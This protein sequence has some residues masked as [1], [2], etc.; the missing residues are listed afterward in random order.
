MDSIDE[1]MHAFVAW[2]GEIPREAKRIEDYRAREHAVNWIR[3]NIGVGIVHSYVIG[4]ELAERWWTLFAERIDTIAPDGAEC[5]HIEA[6]NHNGK[7]WSSRFFY[8]P[9]LTRWRHIRF[10]DDGD[11]YGRHGARA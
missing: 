8:W 7:S 5:W 10:L 9:A 6:Y 11:D 2:H 1:R 4:Y 3:R